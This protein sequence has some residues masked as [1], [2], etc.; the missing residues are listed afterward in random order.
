MNKGLLFS[1][2]QPNGAMDVSQAVNAYKASIILSGETPGVKWIK[3]STS[4]AVLS[5]I[6]LTLIFPFSFAFKILSINVEVF[7]ENG[8]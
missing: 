3:I 7:V 1:I 5:S 8:I 2:T 4:A 6:F